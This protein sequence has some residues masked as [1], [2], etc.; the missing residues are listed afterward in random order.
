MKRVSLLFMSMLLPILASAYDV[1][2]NGI[3]YNLNA[4]TKTATV[5]NNSDEYYSGAVTIP[6]T[7]QPGG[8]TYQVTT[9]GR[10][11]FLGCDKLKSV[12]IPNSVTSIEAFA[13]LGCNLL[14]S[15]TIPGSVK[16][17]GESVFEVCDDLNKVVFEQ[18]VTTIGSN[19]F[20]QCSSLT[21]VTLPNT[22]KTIDYNA[23]W[24]CSGLQSI[25]IPE[26]VT[27]I[28]CDA[29]KGCDLRSVTI[30]SSVGKVEEYAFSNCE[31]LQTV[32]I[33]G[34]N[35][36]IS[37]E[38]FYKCS[39]IETV[40][41]DCQTIGNW[42]AGQL[43][44]KTVVLG[45]H[46]KTISEGAFK[47]CSDLSNLTIGNNVAVIGKEA[48]SGCYNLLKVVI[49][50]SVTTIGEKAFEGC[51]LVYFNIGTGV[52]SIGAGAFNCG[53]YSF[54]YNG[55]NTSIL[56]SLINSSLYWVSLGDNVNEIPDNLF[57]D[58][59]HLENAILG[60][61]ITKI[62]NHAFDGCIELKDI[63]IPNRVTSIGD[64]AFDGC[65]N[66]DM[67]TIGRSVSSIGASAFYCCFDLKTV[68]CYATQVPSTDASAFGYI[69]EEDNHSQLSNV[70]LYVPAS[71]SSAYANC[72]PWKYFGTI[73]QI[74]DGI[75]TEIHETPS[76]DQSQRDVW[77]TLD[78]RKVN[79]K[80]TK[81]G[82]Y[83]H[84]GKTVVN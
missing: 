62:G 46:V 13:F 5:T 53:E 64:Y 67:V 72:A 31:N 36:I 8:V 28:G 43:K 9:I 55:S 11:A 32:T 66:L 49:P 23:F 82:V 52:T 14:T 68:Y 29:F 71:S 70:T 4:S 60:N 26:G 7:I 38:T 25:T 20:K 56:P 22:L 16:T 83:I 40:S 50:N 24:S 75:A 54:S 10:R 77:Y 42:F 39:S 35:P 34:V 47:G 65:L 18:G 84:N 51:S 17:F 76:Q 78:G 57:K 81:R 3:Y 6:S 19:M 12:K 27:E 21:S 15:V 2:V 48:F 41:L 79:G 58:C 61:G 33:N 73:N 37:A 63:I 69:L 80:P 45:S 30:P 74:M 44:L 59:T 1:K